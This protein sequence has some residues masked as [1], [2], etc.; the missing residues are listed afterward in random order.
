VSVRVYRNARND[1]TPVLQLD[2]DAQTA[3]QMVQPSDDA[4]LL[5]ATDMAGQRFV[6][7]YFSPQAAARDTL[8]AFEAVLRGMRC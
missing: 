6:E 4:Q 2:S 7:R 1:E 8:Q 3:L 5:E